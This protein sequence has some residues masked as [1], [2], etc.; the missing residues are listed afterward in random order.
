MPPRPPLTH[1]LCLPLVTETSR[2]QLQASLDQLAS[3]IHDNELLAGISNPE[4]VIRPLGTLHLTLGVM[5]LKKPHDLH[6]A[7][8]LLRELEIPHLMRDVETESLVPDTT[9]SSP[10]KAG[11]APLTVSLTSLQS[12]SAASKTTILYSEPIDR[13]GRLRPLCLFLR[14]AF[15]K[16]GL[17]IPESR[18]LLLHA[19]VVNTVYAKKSK[20]SEGEDGVGGQGAGQPQRDTP[21]R[22]PQKRLNIDATALISQY[23]GVVLARN[24]PLEKLTICK[25]GAQ[26]ILDLNGNFIGEEYE[27]VGERQLWQSAPTSSV[28]GTNVSGKRVEEEQWNG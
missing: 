12:M 3:K 23:S 6:R 5:S 18:P 22:R 26:P 9:A 10:G 11:I 13:N 14:E 8:E 28:P 24:I 17:L 19:T 1:F 25:M 21:S 4:R 16:A 15:E 2:P 7:L 20:T 27:V